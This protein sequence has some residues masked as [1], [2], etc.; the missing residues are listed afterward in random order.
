MSSEKPRWK[1]HLRQALLDRSMYLERHCTPIWNRRSLSEEYFAILRHRFRRF[2]SIR[3]WN[4]RVRSPQRPGKSELIR[5]K[6]IRC[7]PWASLDGRWTD[8]NGQRFSIPVFPNS[9]SNR[10]TDLSWS[11]HRVYSPVGLWNTPATRLFAVGRL[12]CTTDKSPMPCWST[13]W[14]RRNL[15]LQT[16]RSV[17]E[18]HGSTQSPIDQFLTEQRRSLLWQRR[19]SSI[20]RGSR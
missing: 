7:L 6:F 14:A 9:V 10:W 13:E 2:Q 3:R 17:A 19:D 18:D 8:R 11:H 20:A 4:T 1:L 12:V 15:F 16:D 5:W